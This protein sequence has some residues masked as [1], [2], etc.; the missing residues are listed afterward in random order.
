MDDL[1]K[2]VILNNVRSFLSIFPTNFH[3][4][5]PPAKTQKVREK[6]KI[7]FVFAKYPSCSGE[8]KYGTH[9]FLIFQ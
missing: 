3:K 1:K 6:L 4:N 7:Y 9:T 2:L 5:E 8:S